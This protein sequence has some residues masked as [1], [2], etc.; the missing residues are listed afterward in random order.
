MY[1]SLGRHGRM[2]EPVP[3]RGPFA[4]Y[5]YQPWSAGWF[6]ANT[7]WLRVGQAH[8]IMPVRLISG[9]TIITQSKERL[10]SS[11]VAHQLQSQFMPPTYIGP[12]NEKCLSVSYHKLDKSPDSLFT[13]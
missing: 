11:T 10:E 6:V 4:G 7:K 12:P 13:L 9:A 5:G 3:S 1:G 2:N 8:I